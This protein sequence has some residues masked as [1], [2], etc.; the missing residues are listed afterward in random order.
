MTEPLVR[1]EVSSGPLR[2]NHLYQ[3]MFW[4]Q[5]CTDFAEQLVLVSITWAALHTFG[6]GTLGLILAT[7]AVPRGLL[8]L[9]GGV[10]VDRSD[11]RFLAIAVGVLLA[12]LNLAAS[13][14]THHKDLWMWLLLAAALGVLDAVRLPVGSAV[15]PLLVDR[16]RLVQANRWVSLR[17]WA[18]MTA[19]PALGGVLV[20]ARW[21]PRTRCWSGPACTSPAAC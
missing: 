6:G 21:A 1:P 12:L 13:S 10:L 4:S 14:I 17:E 15:L 7:W 18:A 5:T 16:D 8:L 3:A 11:R 19:G 9:F 20:A 2:R